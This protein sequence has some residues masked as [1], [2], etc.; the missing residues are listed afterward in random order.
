[1]SGPIKC[2]ISLQA[3]GSLASAG[4]T[5]SYVDTPLENNLQIIAQSLDL[6]YD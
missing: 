3:L 2:F 1:M 4:L 5:M 6:L